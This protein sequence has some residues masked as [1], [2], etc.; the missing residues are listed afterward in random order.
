MTAKDIKRQDVI[1]GRA[2][3]TYTILFPWKILF[4]SSMCT[5][6]LWEWWEISNLSVDFFFSQNWFRLKPI[7]CG[8]WKSCK[9]FVFPSTKKKKKKFPQQ[10]HFPNLLLYPSLSREHAYFSL[11]TAR[12]NSLAATLV[13]SSATSTGVPWTHL[14]E[15][16]YEL[17]HTPAPPFKLWAIPCYQTFACLPWTATYSLTNMLSFL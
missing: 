10:Q 14:R 2:D 16:Q 15:K 1:H 13:V 8:L 4:V 7:M 12:K 5:L 3:V 6:W 11:L 9:R 17:C